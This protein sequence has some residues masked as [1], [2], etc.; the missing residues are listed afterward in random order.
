MT[1][2]F[3]PWYVGFVGD[4]IACHDFKIIKF[5]SVSWGKNIIYH[6]HSCGKGKYSRG[7]KRG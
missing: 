3:P 2:L 4:K 6:T 1:K 5:K 7:K